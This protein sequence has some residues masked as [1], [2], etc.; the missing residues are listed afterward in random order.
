MRVPLPPRPQLECTPPS[1]FKLLRLPPRH[2]CGSARGRPSP[3]RSPGASP[4][5][6][7]PPSVH[8]LSRLLR[9][10]CEPWSGRVMAPPPLERPHS[11]P[12]GSPSLGPTLHPNSVAFDTHCLLCRVTQGVFASIL[13][14]R[15]AQMVPGQEVQT[16]VWMAGDEP[17]SGQPT[18][19][20]SHCPADRGACWGTQKLGKGGWGGGDRAPSWL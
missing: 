12:Q 15:A 3:A 18:L 11:A 16:R 1:K 10:P 9:V 4:T 6:P 2:R 14:T 8:H 5:C 17:P 19:T 20:S 7:R 13:Q